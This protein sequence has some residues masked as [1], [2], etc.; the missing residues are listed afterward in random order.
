MVMGPFDW[1][2]TLNHITGKLG[3]DIKQ[4]TIF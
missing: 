3:I 4:Q 1:L 2:L